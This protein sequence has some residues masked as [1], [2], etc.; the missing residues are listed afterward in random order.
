MK[1]DYA[2]VEEYAAKI[3]PLLPLA[4]KAYGPK[5]QA[6][7]A[8]EASREYTR[9]LKEFH[10]Q[11]GSLLALAGEIGV[12]YSGMRRRV[13]TAELP[14]L[15]QGTGKPKPSEEE[16]SAAI[17]RVRI[18]KAQGPARYHQQLAA[19]YANGY[20]LGVIAKGL[21]ITNSSPLYYGVQQHTRKT[22][23]GYG[24]Q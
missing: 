9:L 19:E 6:T 2:L 14:P 23:T 4:R 11:G 22:L 1:V 8:H 13:F 20:S 7:P 16:M 21:G 5:D 10:D 17:E 3:K 15:R 18:A 24:Q 12:T